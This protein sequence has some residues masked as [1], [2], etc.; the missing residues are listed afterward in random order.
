MIVLPYPYDHKTLPEYMR[1][2]KPVRKYWDMLHAKSEYKSP[3]DQWAWCWA[4][5]EAKECA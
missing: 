3:A 1:A 4:Q 2:V 5:P